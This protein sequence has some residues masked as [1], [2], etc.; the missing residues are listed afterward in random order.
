MISKEKFTEV[1]NEAV[2]IVRNYAPVD[3]G[4]LEE[5]GVSFEWVDDNT[6]NIYVDEALAPYMPYTNEVWKSPRWNGKKNPNEGWWQY[7]V[8]RIV[9][10]LVEELDGEVK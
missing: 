1:C 3:T 9:K 4:N 8:E 10:Y 6:F 7:S 5:N 2:E